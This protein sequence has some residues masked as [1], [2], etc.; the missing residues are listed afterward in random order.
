MLTFNIS[1]D[2]LT[3]ATLKCI[4][5][6]LLLSHRVYINIYTDVERT[7]PSALPFSF[8]FSCEADTSEVK[9]LDGTLS[10]KQNKRTTA[11]GFKLLTAERGN[12]TQVKV[13]DS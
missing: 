1:T 13:N 7:M 5:P 2:M 12:F 4:K 6:S 11:E 9:P 3:L 10:G 8:G